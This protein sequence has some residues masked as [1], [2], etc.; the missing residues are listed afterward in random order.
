MNYT[1]NQLQIFL[2]VVQTQSVTKKLD[3]AA[4][5]L[6]RQRIYDDNKELSYWEDKPDS[7]LYVNYCNKSIVEQLIKVENFN[8]VTSEGFMADLNID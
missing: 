4:G 7:V 2:K 1:L 5:A 6:V 8:T 3:I